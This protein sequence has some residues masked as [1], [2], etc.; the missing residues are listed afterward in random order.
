MPTLHSGPS[1]L[2]ELCSVLMRHRLHAFACSADISKAFLQVG[3]TD[4]DR[5]STRFLWPEDPTDPESPVVTYRFRVVLFGATCSQFLLNA[6]LLHHLTIDN[7]A[8]SKS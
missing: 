4:T 2:N 5:E 7:S 6:T 3:L 8:T 1:L